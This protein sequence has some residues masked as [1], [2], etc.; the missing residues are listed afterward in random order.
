MTTEKTPTAPAAS[1]EQLAALLAAMKGSD[2]VELKLTVPTDE[3]RA[4]IAGLPIDPVE[5]QPRQVF[6][7][8]TPDL[9]LDK[10]GVVVR[11][12]RIQGGIGDTVVKLRPVVPADLPSAIRK[13]P[14]FKVELDVLPGGIG[15]VSG[16]F[17]GVTTGAKIR[18]AVDGSRPISKLFSKEQ[19]AFFTEHAPAGIDLDRLVALGPTFIL[20]S[21]FKPAEFGRRIVAELWLYQDGSR[22]LEISTK[23]LPAE[24]FQVAAESRVYLAQHGVTIGGQQATKT[25]T[26]L[27]FFSKQLAAASSA[28]ASSAAAATAAEAARPGRRPKVEAAE[29]AAEPVAAAEPASEPPTEAAPAT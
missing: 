21:V 20:K 28:A 25:R 2:S 18:Q 19:R 12:R 3:H 16:S 29:A 4:T 17:K 10:A 22:I 8:D 9:A 14:M 11:A 13:S 27:E 5:A 6:F 26:A 23:S 15:V 7:F 1:P 24:A